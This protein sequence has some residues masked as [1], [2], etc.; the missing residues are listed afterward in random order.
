MTKN[1]SELI[2]RK[3]VKFVE[4]NP[5]CSRAMID[6]AMVGVSIKHVWQSIKHL[7]NYSQYVGANVTY[8]RNKIAFSREKV[9][10]KYQEPKPSPAII[11]LSRKMKHLVDEKHGITG[12]EIREKLNI[13]NTT[14]KRAS[15]ILDAD[16]C[17]SYGGKMAYYPRGTM[18]AYI[19]PVKNINPSGLPEPYIF[20]TDLPILTVWRTALPWET[21]VNPI[22]V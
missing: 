21:R 8:T 7:F 18:P 13:T 16:R 6:K 2:A 15:M 12:A 17:R 4:D 11:S 5:N 9:T 10:R 19:K 22:R 3:I 1:E 14:F 20:K